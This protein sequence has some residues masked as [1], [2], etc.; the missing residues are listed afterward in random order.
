MEWNEDLFI[1]KLGKENEWIK[2][3]VSQSPNGPRDPDMDHITQQA[4]LG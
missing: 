4:G 3:N 1:L 2:R